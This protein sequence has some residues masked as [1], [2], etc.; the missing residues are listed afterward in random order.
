[1]PSSKP[2]WGWLA[3]GAAVVVGMA[4]AEEEEEDLFCDIVGSVEKGV[5]TT[6][7]KNNE[8]NQ[9]NRNVTQF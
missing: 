5:L 8:I 2:I 4:E 9:T 1:M 6:N 3:T 7:D